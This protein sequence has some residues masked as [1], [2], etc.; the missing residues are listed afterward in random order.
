LLPEGTPPIIRASVENIHATTGEIIIEWLEKP[1]LDKIS[2]EYSPEDFEYR[3]FYSVNADIWGDIPLYTSTVGSRDTSFIH[4]AINTETVFPHYY[5]VEL[6]KK[7]DNTIYDYDYEIASTF[8]PMLVPS[9]R[10]VE[11]TFGR[12][13][14]PWINVTY[15][16]YRWTADEEKKWVG[17]TLPFQER[18][19]DVDLVNGITY[20]Y[21]IRSEGYRIIDG[22]EYPN[23]NWS[24]IACVTPIDPIPPC[25]PEISISC[26]DN[27]SR[28]EW[29]YDP[30][31]MS[32][33]ERFN[34]YFTS[35][36]NLEFVIIHSEPVD[37]IMQTQS[38]L[39]WTHI[40]P[41]AGCYYVTAVNASGRESVASNIICC[42]AY[43]IPNVF[44]PNFDT[45]NDVLIAHNPGGVTRVNMMIY[46]R[47][48]QLVFKTED[49][50]INWDGRHIDSKRFVPSGIYYYL[51]DVYEDRLT[52]QRIIPLSGFVHVYYGRDAQPFI[53]P[54]D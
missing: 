42:G 17:V 7:D 18:F 41:L 44:S 35:N 49:P 24:H 3:L 19:I 2:D 4:T 30:V 51:C 5:K 23:Y 47:W 53:P 21:H 37:N 31:C 45:I 13:I 39:T 52:G 26:D 36:R 40:T 14:T 12:R 28:I 34:I 15:D 33:V 16:I 29:V 20:C 38:T 6:W 46:N 10:S 25:E 43:E 8:Y 50:D 54:M 27:Q 32:D 11:I 48:G 9:N 22:I 1:V